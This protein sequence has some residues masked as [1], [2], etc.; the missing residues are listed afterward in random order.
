M[1]EKVDRATQAVVD[2]LISG[3]LSSLSS[4]LVRLALI[5]PSAF[6][7]A[8]IGLL[9]TDHPKT[10][11]S[12]MI[13]L[14][15]QGSGDFYHADGRVYGAVYTDHMLLCKKAHPSG[16]GILLEDVRA[17]VTKARNEHEELI[18]KKV[19]ALE[20]IFQEI[21]TLVAGHSYA[22]SK[23]L[24]LAHAELVRGKAL[25]WAALNPPKIS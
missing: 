20:G 19:Q 22:D 9:N 5:S 13:G 17:A 23:L 24:S 7:Y 10:V 16:V 18:V 15:G 12:I 11:S 8:T 6:L 1:S 4:A 14:C 25:L 2:S 21:D 3:S